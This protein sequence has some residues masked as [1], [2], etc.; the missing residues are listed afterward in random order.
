MIG[1]LERH[2]SKN[3]SLNSTGDESKKKTRYLDH[4]DEKLQHLQ[5]SDVFLS[6]DRDLHS[7]KEI[8]RVHHNVHKGVAS[9]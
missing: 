2:H 5:L 8:I 3:D 7:S 6:G 1:T 9:S 4:E